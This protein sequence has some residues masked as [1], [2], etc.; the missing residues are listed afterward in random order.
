[1]L[2]FYASPHPLQTTKIRDRHT[3]IEIFS[4][5]FGLPERIV[6]YYSYVLQLK[7]L[8]TA[9]VLGTL[10]DVRSTEMS[11]TQLLSSENL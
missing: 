9:V 10:L 2:N 6:L 5:A 8:S 1:M 4:F 11:E 7:P 3:G